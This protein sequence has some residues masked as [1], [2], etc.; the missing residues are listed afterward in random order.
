MKLYKKKINNR[1][2]LHAEINRLKAE[3]S[4]LEEEGL[5]KSDEI[6]AAVKTTALGGL[7]GLLSSKLTGGVAG[8]I[9][10]IAMKFGGSLAGMFTG[11]EGKGN[12]DERGRAAEEVD[13]EEGESLIDK[14]KE[15]GGAVLRQVAREV[16]G[17]YLKWKALELSYKGLSF[18]IK[19]QKA[20]RKQ[21]SA[22]K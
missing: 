20:K 12:E 8:M 9:L 17:N 4:R 22:S 5:I 7:T 13:E 15:N 10:P 6:V 18:V 21:E 1:A 19:K 2:E 16:L 11:S 14:V 3:R